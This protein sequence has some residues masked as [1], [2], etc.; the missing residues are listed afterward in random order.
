MYIWVIIYNRSFFL[1]VWPS[2]RSKL[3]FFQELIRNNN[4]LIGSS[5]VEVVIKDIPNTENFPL[6]SC[7]ECEET[8]KNANILASA[9]TINW[10]LM[11]TSTFDVSNVVS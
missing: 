9:S 6:P 2:S 10:P 5:V 11:T 7:A 3:C 8:W 1:S 4:F